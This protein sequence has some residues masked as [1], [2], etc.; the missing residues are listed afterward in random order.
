MPQTP[1]QAAYNARRTAARRKAATPQTH[2]EKVQVRGEATSLRAEVKQLVIER[3]ELAAMVAKF[4][5]VKAE[6]LRIPKWVASPQ[7]KRKSGEAHWATPV[8]MLSDLHLDEVVDI[9]E[10]DGMNEYDRAIALARLERVV[11]FT[12]T[13]CTRYATGFQYEGIVVALLGDILTGIIH[14]ELA[15]TNEALPTESIVFWVPYLASA[16]RRFADVF[17]KV[18]VPTVDG[19]HDRTTH[20]IQMKKRAQSSYAWVLYNWLADTLRDD[21][22]I[23][24]SIAVAPEQIISVYN[25]RLLLTHGDGFRSAGGVGGIYPSMLKFLH[26]KHELYARTGKGFDVA[27][28]G[29]WHQ[30]LTGP[31]FVVNGSLKGYDEY[32][33][34]SGFGFEKAR[35]ALFF[36]TPERG[37]TTH[38]PVYADAA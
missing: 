8:L 36:V 4:A 26:R 34:A 20:R 12:I 35:Q 16:L 1:A 30:Y 24:F 31:D 17:G 37:I 11:E 7:Q 33:K 21:K 10:M 23:E 29:H 13:Y 25:T 3:D 38:T 19:N 28:M 9:A 15:Q 14:A 5:A 6:D 32:A 2:A 18:F 27:L 22:R